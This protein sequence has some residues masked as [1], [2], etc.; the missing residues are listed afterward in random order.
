[1]MDEFLSEDEETWDHVPVVTFNP[2]LPSDYPVSKRL[3]SKAEEQTLTVAA[4][5]GDEKAR[6][7]MVES[8]IRLVVSVARRYTCRSMTAED[9]IQEGIIGLFEAIQKFDESLGYKFSTYATYWIRQAIVRAIEKQD[10]MIRL[11]AYGCNAERKVS[12]A[13][14]DLRDTL[15]REPTHKE[16]ALSTGLSQR[17]VAALQNMGSEPISLDTMVGENGDTPLG[18]L[19][20][21]EEALEPE[22]DCLRQVDRTKLLAVL[23][24]LSARERMVIKRRFGIDCDGKCSLR[25]I[26]IDLKMSRE[27]VRHMQNRTLKRLRRMLRTEAIL[28]EMPRQ[29]TQRDLSRYDGDE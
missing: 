1:M 16:I 14:I 17:L 22:L 15:G 9:L 19:L 24:R 6:N 7:L 2:F 29:P 26:A 8:N 21:D 4:R 27:G 13:R 23:D 10:R 12:K 28:D 18:D 11:P 25:E 20:V 5:A 3:L